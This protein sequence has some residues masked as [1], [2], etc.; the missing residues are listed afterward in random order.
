MWRIARCHRG[1][2]ACY[3]SLHGWKS[4][5]AL[6]CRRRLAAAQPGCGVRT[7]R[8][9]LTQFDGSTASSLLSVPHALGRQQLRRPGSRETRGPISC[10]RR[11]RPGSPASISVGSDRSSVTSA[12]FQR[13][14]SHAYNT[15]LGSIFSLLGSEAYCPPV[16][17][18]RVPSSTSAQ[19]SPFERTANSLDSED[20]RPT[21]AITR[22]LSLAPLVVSGFPAFRL[23]PCRLSCASSPG[24]GVSQTNAHSWSLENNSLSH[25]HQQLH[26]A[27]VMRGP[28]FTFLLCLASPIL[29]SAST[30]A[31]RTLLRSVL[32]DSLLS[33]VPAKYVSPL[34]RQFPAAEIRVR[35]PT[36]QHLPA[37]RAPVYF[38]FPFCALSR[39][40]SWTPQLSFRPLMGFPVCD[41]RRAEVRTV[42]QGQCDIVEKLRTPLGPLFPIGGGT[43]VNRGAVHRCPP[44]SSGDFP[45]STVDIDSLDS[46]G[47]RPI[48]ASEPCHTLRRHGSDTGDVLTGEGTGNEPSMADRSGLKGNLGTEGLLGPVRS[49]SV[50]AVGKWM[51]DLWVQLWKGNRWK[52]AFRNFP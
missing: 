17:S 16:Q 20:A 48:F 46:R 51:R 33:Y 3:G 43:A 41:S 7:P 19:R 11:R 14:T 28:G 34:V 10:R 36:P 25:S 31:P 22:P 49:L 15:G 26:S 4:V 35:S 32:F 37:S 47:L 38:L 12:V 8:N 5:R 21:S 1:A 27:F 40:G 18:S 45:S 24:L 44:Q 23:S 9:C 6:N 42:I 13:P 30:S 2:Y 50:E 39:L 52:G 29:S